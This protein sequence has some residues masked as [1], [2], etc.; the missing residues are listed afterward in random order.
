MKGPSFT[1]TKGSRALWMGDK[2]KIIAVGASKQSARQYAVWDARALQKPLTM[3]D[4]DTSAGVLIPYYDPDNSVSGW[5]VCLHGVTS[6]H[7]II[8][9]A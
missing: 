5:I 2:G 8:G 1:G 6:I 4:I 3:V 7:D 9:L